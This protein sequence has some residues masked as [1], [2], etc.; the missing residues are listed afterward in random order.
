MQDYGICRRRASERGKIF[1]SGIQRKGKKAQA[2]KTKGAIPQI[3]D[4]RIS[5]A[6]L[7]IRPPEATGT[8]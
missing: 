2:V 6:Y 8:R 7:Q 1:R 4:V 3:I 5:T